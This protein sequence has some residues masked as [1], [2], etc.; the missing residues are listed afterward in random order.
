[1]RHPI[2]AALLCA[3]TAAA[4]PPAFPLHPQLTPQEQA[5]LRSQAERVTCDPDQPVAAAAFGVE[6]GS[7]GS[8]SLITYPNVVTNEG[9]ALKGGEA[10]VAPCTGV[11]SF[12]ISFNTESFQPCPTEV[13]TQDDVIVYFI[14]STAPDHDDAVVVGNWN[15]AW[16]GQLIGTPVKEGQASYTVDLQLNAKDAIQTKV[17]SDGGVPRCLASANFSG[18]LVR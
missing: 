6:M 18:H 14:K 12:S 9:H 1:M 5:K 8:D 2:L 15:G 7:S 17:Y 13:G 10:F 16:R 11:Y 4:Q 3:S